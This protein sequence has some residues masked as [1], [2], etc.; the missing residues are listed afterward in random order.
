MLTDFF[1]TDHF[2]VLSDEK[3]DELK[4]ENERIPVKGEYWNR[5]RLALLVEAMCYTNNAEKIATI[6][7]G[8]TALEIA[9]VG[10]QYI[11]RTK[12]PLPQYTFTVTD[13]RTYT[14]TTEGN[15]YSEAKHKAMQRDGKIPNEAITFKSIE[16]V[17]RS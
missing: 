4:Q 6:F 7:P 2:N 17:K 1:I 13:E 11:H 16:L 14:I 12:N 9:N 10:D 8:K 3:R 5:D 15:T